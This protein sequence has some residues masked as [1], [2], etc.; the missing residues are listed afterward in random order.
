MGVP[1]NGGAAMAI[2]CQ[3]GEVWWIREI[4]V[5]QTLHSELFKNILK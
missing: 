4:L 1:E 3:L 5:F 2:G